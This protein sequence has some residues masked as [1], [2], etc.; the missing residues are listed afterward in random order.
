M[1]KSRS[2]I[3][4]KIRSNITTT[5]LK[6]ESFLPSFLY[7]NYVINI[8]LRQVSF[9]REHHWWQLLVLQKSLFFQ[10]KECFLCVSIPS[11][12]KFILFRLVKSY[13]F[14]PDSIIL[15]TRT[16]CQRPTLG[17]VNEWKWKSLSCVQI[18]NP[19]AYTVYGIVLAR[20]LSG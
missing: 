11:V 20:I 15:T 14:T 12:L 18:C 8:I 17:L 16:K 10:R 2:N 3:R 5:S 4:F 1:S 19:V 9:S 13:S 6:M 7:S